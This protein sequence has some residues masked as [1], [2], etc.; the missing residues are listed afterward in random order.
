MLQCA[1][2]IKNICQ[3]IQTWKVE[4]NAQ[5]QSQ[6]QPHHQCPGLACEQPGSSPSSPRKFVHHHCVSSG[7]DRS[8]PSPTPH[9]H[10]HQCSGVLLAADS[11][12]SSPTPHH[13]HFQQCSPIL[14]S[15]FEQK[16]SS[17]I[18][19]HH[20]CKSLI[21]EHLSP[22]P[23]PPLVSHH[24]PHLHN[25][26]SFL[27][28]DQPNTSPL[29]KRRHHHLCNAFQTDPPDSTPV[30][31]LYNKIEEIY[32]EGTPDITSHYATRHQL[33]YHT[34]PEKKGDVQQNESDLV[35]SAL[36]LSSADTKNLITNE[37]LLKNTIVL[38]SESSPN[39]STTTICSPASS[40][41]SGV[42]VSYRIST[43]ERHKK[44]KRK[45]GKSTDSSSS[46][47]SKER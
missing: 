31:T 5:G 42:K 9:H 16:R 30:L 34:E 28:G 26:C 24:H 13:H 6:L 27:S 22:S 43:V 21:P 14:S 44:E 15:S 23:T 1:P 33:I 19:H 40:T 25:E 8:S 35:S 46:T 45:K 11:P 47:S 2:Y 39:S 20:Q 32:A 3:N 12:R 18:P 38:V 29:F 10:H 17:P 41:S 36:K 4:E 37:E 7:E